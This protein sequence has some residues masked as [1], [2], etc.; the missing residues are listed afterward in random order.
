MEVIYTQSVS[1]TDSLCLWQTVFVCQ[2]TVCFCCIQSLYITES[3]WLSQSIFYVTNSLCLSQTVCVSHRQSVS[4]TDSLFL[5]QTVCVCHRQSVSADVLSPTHPVC[6]IHCQS[7]SVT[8][9]LCES[10]TLFLI[11]LEYCVY[12]WC[13]ATP[14]ITRLEE[15]EWSSKCSPEENCSEL[16]DRNTSWKC[17]GVPK[18]SKTDK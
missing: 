6:I 14:P 18:T 10:K 17:S 13:Q 15:T 16:S 7:M 2:Q 12:P 3:M 11:D 1:V 5:A 4:L 8:H 9:S